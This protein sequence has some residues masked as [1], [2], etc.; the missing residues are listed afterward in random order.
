MLFRNVL[1]AV[2][3]VAMMAAPA[4]ASIRHKF[5][6]EKRHLVFNSRQLAGECC[7]SSNVNAAIQL[8]MVLWIFSHFDFVLS[9]SHDPQCPS[10]WSKPPKSPLF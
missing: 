8:S 6:K 4:E 3:L 10:A 7:K 1:A 2:A 5:A 9:R